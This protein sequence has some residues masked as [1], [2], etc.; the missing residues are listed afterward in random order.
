MQNHSETTHLPITEKQKRILVTV[1]QRTG[2]MAGAMREAGISSSRTAYLWWHRFVEEGEAGLAPRS[3]ARKTQ[4]TIAEGIVGT[5]RQLRQVHPTW[6]RRRIA[7]MVASL[8]GNHVVSPAGVE[9]VLR[10]AQLWEAA[11]EAQEI[12]GDPGI[13]TIGWMEHGYIDEKALVSLIQQGLTISQRSDAEGTRQLFQNQLWTPQRDR[14]GLWEMIS[15]SPKIGQ[16][17]LRSRVALAHSLMNTG[18]WEQAAVVLAENLTWMREHESWLRH[19]R[20]EEELAFNLRWEDAWVESLQYLGI[21]LQETDYQRA[22]AYLS[23]ALIG[24]DRKWRPVV[25]KTPAAMLSNVRR[26]IASLKIKNGLVFGREIERELEEIVSGV[27][28]AHLVPG[29]LAGI[30]IL[31]AKLYGRRARSVSAES[32]MARLH[33]LERMEQAVEQ[34]LA[35]VQ[36][37]PSPMLQANFIADAAQIYQEHG[38]HLDGQLLRQAAHSCLAYGYRREAGQL[39]G[40]PAIG[41]FLSEEELHGLIRLVGHL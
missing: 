12:V 37:D 34:T 1:Y 20:W 4:R 9:A 2:N 30:G 7:E 31:W 11:F 25:P 17:L 32:D 14:R 24:L 36:L 16:W 8:Y 33:E 13:P 35:L 27:E 23:T 3:H 10:R 6:G 5:V 39:I 41:Q 28:A 22:Q 38:M 19:Q 21:V 29:K 40:L 26:D 18:R 15:R